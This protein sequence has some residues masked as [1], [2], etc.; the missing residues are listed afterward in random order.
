MS[1]LRLLW[2][3]RDWLWSPISPIDPLQGEGVGWRVLHSDGLPIAANDNQLWLRPRGRV[4]PKGWYLFLIQHRGDNPHVT[5]LLRSGR[6]GMS[7][8]RPLF[9]IR[10]RFRVVHVNRPRPLILELQQVPEPMQLKRLCLVRLPAWEAWRRIRR[11]L[12]RLDRHLPER[13]TERWRYYNHLLQAQANCHSVVNYRRWQ[14]QIES[15]LLRALPVLSDEQ[16]ALFV[17]ADLN[18]PKRVNPDQWVVLVRPGAVMSSWSLALFTQHLNALPSSQRPLV[19]YGDE[20]HW[21][22]I[23]RHSPRF[24]PAWNRE[25]FLSDPQYSSHWIVQGRFWNELLNQES[26]IRVSLKGWWAL[27]YALLLEA[28]QRQSQ[29]Q[30]LIRHLPLITGHVLSSDLSGAVRAQREQIFLRWGDD[31]PSLITTPWGHRLHWACPKL[32]VLSVI[33]PTRDRLSLLQAC[34]DSIAAVPAGVDIEVIVVDN[35]S[36]EPSS[37]EYLEHFGQQSNCSVLR[38][39]GPFNFSALTNKAAIKA[40]GSVLLLLNNDV[41]FL[42]RNWGVELVANA[43]RPEVGCVGAQLHY[44]D[45]TIQ[46]GGVIMGIG[47]IAGHAHAGFAVDQS[48]Y[49][50]RLQLAQEL[51]A[52][53]GACLAISSECW[54]KLGGLDEK[55][56]WVNYNDV[57]LCLRAHSAGFRNLYLPQVKAI[58]H[59]SSSR[60]KPEGASYKRWKKEWAVM[61]QRWGYLLKSDLAYSPWLTL[62]DERFSLSLRQSTPYLR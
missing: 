2:L 29:G 28:D 19:L 41:E 34:L 59:E 23:I 8:G 35:G 57:D 7:Q 58:H 48:G 52:V 22:G 12:N 40:K 31:A 16:C 1:V 32:N 61:E 11:R 39:D 14:A 44:P 60:G 20:D 49:V 10:L 42:S 27:Q 30:R 50:G 21:E 56:L 46:H 26:F 38:D 3:R 37:L 18:E 53:T 13:F 54:Q 9:P 6:Y 5:G 51:T 36:M 25:L 17:Q 4:V 45:G 55:H 43:L 62:E 15:P 47:G 24:K 33:I